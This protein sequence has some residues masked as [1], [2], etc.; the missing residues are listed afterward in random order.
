MIVDHFTRYAQAYATRNKSAK[1]VAEK[2]FN[3][4]IP[5][6][7]YPARL[8]HDQGGEFEN[9][10]FSKL[11][12]LS[13]IQ[14]SRT[15]PYHPQ[16][17]GQV[18][19]FNRTVL[20][21]LRTL[22]ESHKTHWKDHLNKLVHAYNC[23]PHQ[24]TGYSP[25]FLLFGRH[26]RLSIDLMFQ[27]EEPGQ[28]Q[29][30]SQYAANW[31]KA[32]R[33][34]YSLAQQNSKKSTEKSKRLYDRKTH[35]TL[36]EPGDHVLVRNMTP[37]GG[38]GKLRA[39]WEDKVHKVV[40]RL[41]EDSPVYIVEPVNGQSTCRTLHRNMLLPCNQFSEEEQTSEAVPTSKK[42]TRQKPGKTTQH[43]QQHDDYSDSEE[44]F[45][46]IPRRSAR[47][48]RNEPLQPERV[49]M[50]PRQ[51]A[52]DQPA[53]CEQPEAPSP[54]EPTVEPP[55]VPPQ[56]QPAQP[57]SVPTEAVPE[58]VNRPQRARQPPVRFTYYEPGV[59]VT[60]RVLVN[61][62]LL[63]QHPT[64]KVLPLNPVWY[65]WQQ[66]QRYKQP[67]WYH[68]QPWFHVPVC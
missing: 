66:L 5:R 49:Q 59:P 56:T 41:A 21:L 36:L 28:S 13:G 8:H 14:H 19:R 51:I 1:T 15:T 2:L 42:G 20:S 52:R 7:G 11:E 44:D 6:F 32:M 57:E 12:E 34:A 68:Q 55:A 9:K 47:K 58:Q 16:G 3:D 29:T 22:P 45:V 26:P 60:E 67:Q 54:P 38:P 39:F 64:T 10:L 31:E 62:T 65:P 18:E 43:S 50:V 61:S 46:M 48:S 27:I 63:Q 53:V 30:Y 17:N 24:T 25:F 33:E 23:T 37:R 35:S 4:F 40:K